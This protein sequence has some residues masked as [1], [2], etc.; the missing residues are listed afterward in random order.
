[1]SKQATLWI[2]GLG[3]GDRSLMTAQATEAIARAEVIIGYRGYFGGIRELLAGKTCLEMGLGEE[4]QRAQLAVQQA[5][6]GR[7]VCVI[8]SGD[9]GIYG[10]A[11]AVFEA[12]EQADGSSRLE[13]VVVPGV[14]AISAAAALLGAPLG[15]DFAV[16]SLSDLLTPWTAIEQR[17]EAASRADF[18]LALLNPKSQR[19]DWQLARA[20]DIIL[21]HR[22][23]GTPVGV[24]RNAFRAEQAVTL[25]TLEQM[26]TVPVDM[27]TTVIIGNSQT[28]RCGPWMLTPRG[29]ALKADAEPD[30]HR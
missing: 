29:Y 21:Q 1:M 16:I 7:G 8:S 27:F 3:P 15:H 23:P 5:Q 28:R 26:L 2:I 19:R 11:S 24:V 17:L 25:T 13:V 10:M 22:A 14:S 30:E 20:R 12:I 4:V 6:Q 18:V 9:A